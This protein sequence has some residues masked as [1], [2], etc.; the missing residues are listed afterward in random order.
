MQDSS[1]NTSLQRRPLSRHSFSA[2][3]DHPPSARSLL[4]EDDSG[5][6]SLPGRPVEQEINDISVEQQSNTCFKYKPVSTEDNA[7]SEG[8]FPRRRVRVASLPTDCAAVLLSMAMIIFVCLVWKLDGSRVINDSYDSWKN[9]IT[10]LAT[11]FPILFASIVGRLMTEATR[12]KL[13]KGSTIGCLEQLMG[14]QTVGGS[15]LSILRLRS[16]SVLSPLLLL[17]W[18]FSPLGAQSLLR[19]T[20]LRSSYREIQT[21]VTFFDTT[22][23]SQI[24]DWYRRT[25][26][27]ASATGALAKL[28]VLKSLY[29]TLVTAPETIKND[30]MDIWGNVKIPILKDVEVQGWQ[31]TSSH[32][33][34]L[35]YASLMGVPVNNIGEG[36]TS[37]SLESTYVQLECIN[38]TYYDLHGGRHKAPPLGPEEREACQMAHGMDTVGAGAGWRLIVSWVPFG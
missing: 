26:P 35:Q 15:V 4:A 32:R 7:A 36:N 8:K 14:S 16:L 3:G 17:L 6:A 22:A 31:N 11:F 34:T 33:A 5:Q 30:T 20:E 24:A 13:E 19:M 9:A 38:A 37:F 18:S 21:T 2:N 29:T 10:V 27:S 28:R 25:I 1:S 12:W 23:K